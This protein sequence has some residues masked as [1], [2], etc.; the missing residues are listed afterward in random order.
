MRAVF[1]MP[2]D[3][4]LTLTFLSAHSVPRVSVIL[5][6]AALEALYAICFWGWGTKTA[7]MLAVLMIF[8]PPCFSMCLPSACSHEM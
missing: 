4:Q 3:M 8:P 1:T 5:T 7:A 2:G 6:T